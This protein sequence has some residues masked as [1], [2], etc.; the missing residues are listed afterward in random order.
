MLLEAKKLGKEK[1]EHEKSKKGIYKEKF[2]Q[3]MSELDKEL[4]HDPEEVAKV[5]KENAELKAR[6]ENLS[7][8]VEEMDND[9][10]GKIEGLSKKK[11]N[12]NFLELEFSEHE[13]DLKV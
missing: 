8:E 13:K 5:A 10:K 1:L 4:V 3:Y 11:Q 9:Y 6:A 12:F 2:D 7:K